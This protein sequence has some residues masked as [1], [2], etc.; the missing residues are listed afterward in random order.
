MVGSLLDL[1]YKPKNLTSV[2]MSERFEPLLLLLVGGIILPMFEEI[3]FRLS[4]KFKPIYLALT[5]GTF[6][7]YILTKAV[8]KTK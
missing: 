2:S 4:L 7:Y 6:T 1:V 5:A 3:A 8:F